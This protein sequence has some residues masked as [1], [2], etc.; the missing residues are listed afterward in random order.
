M[1]E[2]RA[3]GLACISRQSARYR[4]QKDPQTALRMRLKELAAIR[5]SFG[6]ERL[7]ILLR[8]EGWFVNR[9]RVYRLYKEEGLQVR[10]KQRKKIARRRPVVVEFPTGPNQRWSMD[11]VHDRLED[12]RKFRI[13]TVVDQ[14]T[15]E[16]VA[17]HAKPRL[18]GSDVAEALDLAIR[19]RGKPASITVD[20]GSEF[21]GKVM[22][23]WSD[24]H[25]SSVLILTHSGVKT[26]AHP[27]FVNC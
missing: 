21:A 25:L 6:F 13:L 23:V 4:S 2:R 19:E 3:C 11:F 7:T 5:V 16:C 15:K 27:P 12:G 22:D 24:L 18:M 8:R 10:T 14:F 9:K 17:L 1:G 20:N 26:S